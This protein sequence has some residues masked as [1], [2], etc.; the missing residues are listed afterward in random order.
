MSE[1]GPDQAQPD[2]A[3]DDLEPPAP[4]PAELGQLATTV[5]WWV[6]SHDVAD[7]A[8]APTAILNQ[9]VMLEAIA[10]PDAVPAAAALCGL[11]TNSDAAVLTAWTY[12]PTGQLDHS[13][14]M[15]QCASIRDHLCELRPLRSDAPALLETMPPR[16]RELVDR[17]ASADS[18]CTVVDGP[19]AAACVLLAYELNPDCLVKIRPLQR[20]QSPVE[21]QAWQHLRVDPVLPIETGYGSG[22]L[23]EV[24]ISLINLSLELASA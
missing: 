10:E 3:V 15:T 17:L 20:G 1:V 16:L 14:W 21:T 8:V 11:L 12:T 5:D 19:V 2:P 7:P 13:A 18:Q 24:A 6:Q 4:L 9:T 22:Q 23:M